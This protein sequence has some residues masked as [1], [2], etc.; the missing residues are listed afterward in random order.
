[1]TSKN[2]EKR[3]ATSDVCPACLP[4]WTPQAKRPEQRRATDAEMRKWTEGQR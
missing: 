1:M 4:E 3:T 2:D